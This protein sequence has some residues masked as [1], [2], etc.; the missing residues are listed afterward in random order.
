MRYLVIS[1]IHAN[2]PALKAVLGDAAGD[3]DRILCLGDIVG[4]GP[5]PNECAEELSRLPVTAV[6]GNHDWASIGR[7]D[8]DYF[9]I[10]AR[11]A[12]IWTR[13]QLNSGSREY[14]SRLKPFV[15]EDTFTLFHGALT[16]P[17][18]HYILDSLDAEENFSLL[19]TP[20]GLFGHSHLRFYFSRGPDGQV[21]RHSL[22][23]RNDLDLLHR[24]SLLNPGS[25]GQPR[26][27]DPRAAYGIL[28]TDK[29]LW[30]LRRVEYDIPAVQKRMR[31]CN[32]P[33]YLVRRLGEGR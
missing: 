9:N 13:E 28:D 33:D 14:L 23:E 22:R 17:I 32:L 3:W 24:Q 16:D 7:F 27:G 2:L 5:F 11:A 19:K 29:G 30:F 25:T 31:E 15:Q 18:T 26:E 6:P 4:Y 12:L 8:L 10:H 1:D 21:V 20:L